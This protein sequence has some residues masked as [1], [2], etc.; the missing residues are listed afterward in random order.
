VFASR[1][2]VT[3]QKTWYKACDISYTNS[4]WTGDWRYW[5]NFST[6]VHVAFVIGFKIAA[7]LSVVKTPKAIIRVPC[8]HAMNVVSSWQLGTGNKCQ[9]Q[10]KLDAS[11]CLDAWCSSA[12]VC[13]SGIFSRWIWFIVLKGIYTAATNVVI[14]TVPKVFCCCA[15]TTLPYPKGRNWSIVIRVSHRSMNGYSWKKCMLRT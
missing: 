6:T 8:Y 7:D 2:G 9:Y 13:R 4:R 1:R 5:M 12:G 11:L 10:S 3:Y 15:S 14:V